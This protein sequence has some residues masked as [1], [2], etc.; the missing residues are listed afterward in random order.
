MRSEHQL[1]VVRWLPQ[2]V[3]DK[4]EEMEV[5]A[6]SECQLWTVRRFLQLGAGK[7]EEPESSASSDHR[8]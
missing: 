1:W 2:L 7:P 5:R 6:S 8:S 3:A 4:P